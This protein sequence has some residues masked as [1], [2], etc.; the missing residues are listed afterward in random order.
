M[1]TLI[2]KIYDKGSGN[3]N[4]DEL[5]IKDNLFGV[6][7]GATSIAKFTNDEGKTWAKIAAEI[8]KDVFSNNNKSLEQLTIEANQAI[9]D[10]MNKYKIDITKK[11]ELRGSA[12]ATIKLLGD[13]AEFLTIGDCL[14]LAIFKDGTHK[15][16]APLDDHDWESMK[17]R[18]KFADKKIK[19]IRSE[20]KDQFLKV[21]RES[22]IKY[23]VL[24]WETDAIKFLEIWKINLENVKSLIL[25]TDGLFIPKK[26][27]DD[28]ENWDLFVQ[29]YQKSGLDG[30]LHH[31]RSLEESDPNCWEYP[32]F[33]Q[34]DDVAAIGIDFV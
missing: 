3:Q 24:N 27:P 34:Y 20:L 6:F 33:K 9:W 32:R 25:F 14:I 30:I 5:L 22:N 1:Q 12:I 31:V 19:D 18:K 15:L 4:E 13:E 26:N 28:E 17:M 23:G 2:Q 11:E 10:E 21:R 29:L 8:C 7:D 16:L